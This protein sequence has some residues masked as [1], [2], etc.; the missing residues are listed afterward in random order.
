MGVSN[1]GHAICNFCGAEFRLFTIFNRDMQ[2][3]CKAWRRK[4]EHKCRS[5]LPAER[6]KWARLYIGKDSSESSITVDLSHP[7]FQDL[8]EVEANACQ[9]RSPAREPTV[10]AI[11]SAGDNHQVLTVEGGRGGYRRKPCSDCPWRLD[12]TGEFP[13]EAFKHSA[14]TAYDMAQN[15]FA[16]HQSG[17]K[18]PAICAGFLLRGADHNLS[19]RLAH[20]RGSIDRDVEDGGHLLHPSYRD[21]AIA[22]GVDEDDPI[23]DKCR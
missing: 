11:K 12:A 14:S 16:C 18:K 20:M 22:N 1:T 19:I 13:A 21:M 7:G 23:L 3:L 2:G 8:P 10:T 6:H 9:G 4:H 17:T 5:R 15:T